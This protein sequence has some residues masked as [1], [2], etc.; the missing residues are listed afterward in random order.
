ML[1][2]IVEVGIERPTLNNS[3]PCPRPCLVFTSYVRL[4]EQAGIFHACHAT[5]RLLAR[6]SVS[7][8]ISGIASGAPSINYIL[9]RS[10]ASGRSCIAH[11][12]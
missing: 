2:D 1:S 5:E 7:L 4:V 11:G 6:I 12:M 10:I 9:V 8:P 3:P